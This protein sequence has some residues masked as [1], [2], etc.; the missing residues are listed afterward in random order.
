MR[1][2]N[3]INLIIISIAFIVVFFT[4]TSLVFSAPTAWGIAINPA[5]KTCTNYWAGDEFTSYYL[6]SGW[7]QYYPELAYN[8]IDTSLGSCKFYSFSDFYTKE[9]TDN[10][11][12]CFNSINCIYVDYDN[13]NK[14]F[15]ETLNK[16]FF[17]VKLSSK[18]FWGT[19]LAVDSNSKQCT[20][21]TCPGANKEYS[22]GLE[23]HSP[24]KYIMF[25]T[26]A[27]NCT[28]KDNVENNF[29]ECCSQLGYMIVQNVDDT[30]NNKPKKTSENYY[31]AIVIMAVLFVVVV[32]YGLIL[33]KNYKNKKPSNL[34]P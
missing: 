13:F 8:S 20:L 5:D 24:Q 27:G 28:I 22:N 1:L 11:R 17:C 3:I 29:L 25:K 26:K 30:K 34:W 16:E 23:V 12:S 32:I 15:L 9:I 21:I 19:L 14:S 33:L 2:K 10:W 7:E 4:N 6:P 31:L 18:D